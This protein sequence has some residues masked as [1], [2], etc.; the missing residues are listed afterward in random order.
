MI[1]LLA[2]IAHQ[3]APTAGAAAGVRLHGGDPGGG[4]LT[5]FLHRAPVDRSPLGTELMPQPLSRIEDVAG[6]A[7]EVS[8]PTPEALQ[9]GAGRKGHIQLPAVEIGVS[10]APEQNAACELAVP[11]GAA[12]LLVV[13]LRRRRE[14]PV[15]HQTDVWLVDA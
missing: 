8:A 11:A 12:G 7:T 3:H 1:E 4:A 2:E 5:P 10:L 6:H 15:H 9:L 14:G 13:C